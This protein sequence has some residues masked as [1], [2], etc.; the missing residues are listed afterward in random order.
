MPS[1]SSKSTIKSYS[2]RGKR[3]GARP[4]RE[5]RQA[6]W[7]D[8]P[9]RASE[10]TFPKDALIHAVRFGKKFIRIE[11]TD[12]RVLLI[13]MSWIPSLQN[14]NPK[15]IAKYEIS[16]DRREIIWDPAKCAINDEIRLRDYLGPCGED[17]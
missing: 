7:Y 17:T 8:I 4:V 12:G 6:I 13:P 3:T 14:A 15:E 9:Y 2:A 1:K 11:L 5:S 10:Y 16:R